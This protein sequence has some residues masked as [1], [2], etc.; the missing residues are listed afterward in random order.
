MDRDKIP[1][2]QIKIRFIGDLTLLPLDLQQQ[3]TKT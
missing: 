2:N 1:K 3:C